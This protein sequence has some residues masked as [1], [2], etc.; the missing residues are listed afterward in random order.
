[1]ATRAEWQKPLDALRAELAELPPCGDENRAARLE[2]AFAKMSGWSTEQ[3]VFTVGQLEAPVLIDATRAGHL[4]W[5][6]PMAGVTYFG[7]LDALRDLYAA[8]E[9]DPGKTEKHTAFSS[10]MTWGAWDYSIAEGAPPVMKPE[11]LSQLFDWGADPMFKDHSSSTYFDKA[12]RSSPA[13][14]IHV[15][16]A[17]GALAPL[18]DQVRDA[19]LKAG[20]YKQAGEIQKALGLGGFYTKVDNQTLMETKYIQEPGRT[21]T[22][23]T[24]FNFGAERVSEIFESAGAAPAITSCNFDDYNRNALDVARRALEKLGGDPDWQLTLPG[25]PKRGGLVR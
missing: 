8:M 1:M 15:F 6:E 2:G 16:L 5:W 25:K 9:A 21:S 22:L 13:D 17:H 12:L 10:T 18:A 7:R 11:V 23:R 24:V 3:K 19:L 14:I 20:S 4:R